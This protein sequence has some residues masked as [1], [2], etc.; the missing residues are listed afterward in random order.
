[1][2]KFSWIGGGLGFV[3]GGPIGIIVGAVI[4]SVIDGMNR[5]VSAQGS[6][7]RESTV[8][9]D[10]N[11]SLLVLIAAVM[12]A[13]GKVL[14]SELD[15]VK[16]NLVRML[17][18]DAAQQAVRMLGDLMKQEIPLR[19]VCIQIQQNMPHALRLEMIHLLM[20]ISAADGNIVVEELSVIRKIAAYLN[21]SEADFESIK[22]MFIAN[23]SA[24][25]KI[26][27]VDENAT[28]EE[29]KKAYRKMA[30]KYHHDKVGNL[31]EELAKQ[32]NEK[33][34]KVNEAYNQIKK[35]RGI[36]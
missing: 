32:A 33:F 4:G 12:K 17:G 23:T 19:D 24:A 6:G 14:K 35:Q 16:Q 9:G 15:F 1:M 2:G 34:R 28:D 25:Y 22:A 7:N 3:L 10:F 11:I 29:V 31:D 26:L 21:V 27:E 36:V 13:D 5:P 20:G 18:Q 30:L 8:R